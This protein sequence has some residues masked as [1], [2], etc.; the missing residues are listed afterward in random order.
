MVRA[1]EDYQQEKL[2]ILSENKEV[3][4]A[5]KEFCTG[6]GGGKNMTPEET[7]YCEEE[8]FLEVDFYDLSLGFFIAKGCDLVVAF[9]LARICRYDLQYWR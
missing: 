3:V 1:S 2:R 6:K 4:E 9:N 8:P 7:D 5:F